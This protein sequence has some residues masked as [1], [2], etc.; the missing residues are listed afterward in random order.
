MCVSHP[1]TPW[2]CRATPLAQGTLNGLLFSLLADVL[3]SSAHHLHQMVL[4][5]GFMVLGLLLEQVPSPLSASPC[6]WHT[7]PGTGVPPAPYRGLSGAGV[8]PGPGAEEAGQ[9]R[10][11]WALGQPGPGRECEVELS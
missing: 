1:P 9:V 10:Q 7:H 5:G 6:L 2:L 8:I 11:Q 4:L 3:A